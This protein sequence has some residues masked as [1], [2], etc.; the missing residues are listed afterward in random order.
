MNIYKS[1]QLLVALA[2]LFIALLIFPDLILPIILSIVFSLALL[3]PVKWLESKGVNSFLAALIML[4][5]LAIILTAAGLFYTSQFGAFFSSFTDV[6]PS[7][8]ENVEEVAETLEKNFS[9]DFSDLKAKLKQNFSEI[10]KSGTAMIG[11]TFSAFTSFFSLIFLIPIYVIFMLITRDRLVK[12]TTEN[13]N[14]KDQKFIANFYKEARIGM[15]NYFKG[16][17]FVILIV[18][19][20]NTIGLLIIGIEFAFLLGTFSALLIVIPYIGVIVGALL[21]V[22]VAFITKDSLSY[23]IA[24]AALYAVVQFLEGNVITPK[25]MSGEVN[26]N[27][28]AIIIFLVF[29]GGL[30][31]ILGLVVAVPLLAL[32]KVALSNSPKYNSWAI[33]LKSSSD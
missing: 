24:V 18:G 2:A 23:P 5:I 4:V 21:P 6:S 28:L 13:Y 3:T 26:L 20:L 11:S 9:L 17:S 7:T 12:F 22:A 16:L 1:N 14:E 10:L 30:G 32:I 25:L 29:M 27:P 31:G 19:F 33:L 15:L 8:N